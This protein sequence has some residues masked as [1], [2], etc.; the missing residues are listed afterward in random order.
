VIAFG[1]AVLR[2]FVFGCAAFVVAAVVLSSLHRTVFTM[3]PAP[4]APATPTASTAAGCD[5]LIASGATDTCRIVDQDA[6]TPGSVR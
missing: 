1:K 2:R 3:P 4:I 6:A 5:E